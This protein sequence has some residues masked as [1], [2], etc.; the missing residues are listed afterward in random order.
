[1][2]GLSELARLIYDASHEAGGYR[3]LA[4]RSGGLVSVSTLNNIATGRHTGRLTDQSIRGIALAIGMPAREVARVV[5]ADLTDELPAFVLPKRAN[6][7]S[8]PQR[9]VVVAVIDAILSAGES[10]AR[11]AAESR[12]EPAPPLKRVARR[13]RPSR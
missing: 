8:Q 12:S 2:P 4:R 3:G 9:R 13:R 11:A 10:A 6:R 7:L 5:G 1:V